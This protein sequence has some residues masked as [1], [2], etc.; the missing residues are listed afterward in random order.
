[1]RRV[2]DST[3]LSISKKLVQRTHKLPPLTLRELTTPFHGT[4]LVVV[5]GKRRHT[6]LAREGREQRVD[7]PIETVT[8]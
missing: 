8:E 7:W 4:V 3:D 2:R 1:M 6:R 5:E